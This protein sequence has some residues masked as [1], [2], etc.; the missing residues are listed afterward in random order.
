VA[1]RRSIDD[2]L[3]AAYDGV[4]AAL[5]E[6][7]QAAW[8]ASTTPR[9]AQLRALRNLLIEQ[10]QRLDEAES[11]ID[12]R[13]ARVASPSSH[14][15][16]NLAAE[17]GGDPVRVVALLVDRLRSLVADLRVR[18][19]VIDDHDAASL[20]EEVAADIAAHVEALGPSASSAR[21]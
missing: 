19:A 21:R 5:Y 8:A 16:G 9:A 4:L 6:T 11:A 17:A 7:K 12:G 20:L 15:H 14:Q 1:D 10:S 18:S 2:H 3:V 13:S